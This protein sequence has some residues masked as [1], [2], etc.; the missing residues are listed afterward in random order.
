VIH[1]SPAAITLAM[2]LTDEELDSLEE[3]AGDGEIAGLG[4]SGGSNVASP[5]PAERHGEPAQ[6]F[7]ANA[8]PPGGRPRM[9]GV[10]RRSGIRPERCCFR[11]A[12]HTTRELRIA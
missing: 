12:R 9:D 5:Q 11:V 8:A 3:R 7:P 4:R 2:L 1:A 6:V 10:I